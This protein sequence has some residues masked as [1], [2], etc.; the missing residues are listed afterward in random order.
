MPHAKRTIQS[1]VT[2]NGFELVWHLHREQNLST[3]DGWRGMVIIAK[4]AEGARRELR[5]EYPSIMTARM[6]ALKA[7]SARPTISAAKVKA[8][9]QQAME[10]GWDP[11]SRGQP[12]VHEMDEL[13]G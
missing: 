12:F 11:G 4:A 7:E 6:S 2:I 1:A 13:P 5:L 3:S 10:A 9:I 8:H